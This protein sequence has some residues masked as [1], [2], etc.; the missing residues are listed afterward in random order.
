MFRQLSESVNANKNR[1]E[2]Y[3]LNKLVNKLYRSGHVDLMPYKWLTIGLKQ[4]RLPEFYTLFKIHKETPVGR[5]IVSG[6]S[7][8]TERISSF[9]DSLL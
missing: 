7:G 2:P 9:V 3:I 6:N 1:L 8:P 4:S 5:P